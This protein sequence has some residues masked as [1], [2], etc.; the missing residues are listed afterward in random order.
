MESKQVEKLD[1][2]AYQK[3]TCKWSLIKDPNLVDPH[4]HTQK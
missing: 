4:I 2:E 3:K 1:M